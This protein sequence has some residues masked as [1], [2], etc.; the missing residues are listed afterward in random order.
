MCVCFCDN[1][2]SG[3]VEREGRWQ[4][5]GGQLRAFEIQVAWYSEC[6]RQ[7]SWR[8]G[9][10][11]LPDISQGRIPP[12]LLQGNASEPLRQ[13]IL[14][15]CRGVARLLQQELAIR[16]LLHLNGAREDLPRTQSQGQRR[17]AQRDC[18]RQPPQRMSNGP[19]FPS[20][21]RASLPTGPREDRATP[22]CRVP[23]CRAALVSLAALAIAHR[24]KERTWLFSHL[25]S[26]ATSCSLRAAAIFSM[27]VSSLAG[28]E[29]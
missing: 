15:H 16:L 5:L 8:P 26:A 28:S 4:R 27:S 20:L 12:E 2:L 14:V 23:N 10:A 3:R 13:Q 21:R 18:Q 17:S 11:T 25:F 7:P 1:A 6:E 24:R 9:A 22:L 29:G 19:W